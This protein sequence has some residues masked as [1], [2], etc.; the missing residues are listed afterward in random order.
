MPRQNICPYHLD[1]S[2]HL[3][4]MLNPR[5]KVH[6][7]GNAWPIVSFIVLR[8]ANLGVELFCTYVCSLYWHTGSMFHT[9]FS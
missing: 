2:C 3:V 6:N 5:H 8:S 9:G 7:L 1:S 4:C